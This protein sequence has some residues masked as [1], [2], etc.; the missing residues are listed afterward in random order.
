MVELLA[1]ASG[2]AA[3]GI[4]LRYTWW[5]R[6]QTGIPILMYHQI[7]DEL[8]YTKQ[9]KLRVSP[10]RFARQ[11]DF[12]QKHGYKTLTLSQAL[13]HRG[14]QKAVVLTFDDAYADFYYQAWPLLQQRGMTATLFV[15]TSEVGGCNRW[16]LPKGL[17]KET[18]ITRE[19]LRELDQGGIEIGGHSHSH[20]MLTS[21]NDSRL[22]REIT[23]C[24]KMLTDMTGHPARAFSYPYGLYNDRVCR[25]VARAGFIL[26]CTI[27][28]GKLMPKDTQPL[29][30][31]RIMIK[32]RDDHLDFKLKLS[33][34]QSSL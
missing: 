15:V 26:G 30:I 13:K 16:D 24:Q 32:R 19:Q 10:K 5:R 6:G 14:S 3:L 2:L 28:P 21:L 33:R 25:A 29:L 9:P 1:T 7:T 17:P 12:L 20:A 11:L 31:P 4:S 34:S 18:L 8:N 23:G 22:L 27:K